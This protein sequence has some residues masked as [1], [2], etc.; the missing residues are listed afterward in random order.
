V[1]SQ[2]VPNPFYPSTTIFYQLGE[3]AGVK[4]R[5]FD[6]NGRLV[7]TLVNGRQDARPHQVEWNGRDDTGHEVASG[8]YF[9]QLTAG[10][11]SATRRLVVVR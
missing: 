9:Y 10:S 8:A 11:R 7:R 4:L 6:V 3:A 5:V 2:N 1:L